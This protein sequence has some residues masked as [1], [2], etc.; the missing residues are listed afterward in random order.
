MSFSENQGLEVPTFGTKGRNQG[1]NPSESVPAAVKDIKRKGLSENSIWLT[2]KQGGSLLGIT[3]RAVK[4]N[5]KAGKYVTTMVDGN[6]GRQYR[7]LLSSLPEKAVM[8]W[9]ME[10]VDLVGGVDKMDVLAGVDEGE[11]AIDLSDVHALEMETPKYNKK[12]FEKYFPFLLSIG[13]F[14]TGELP[15]YSELLKLLDVWNCDRPK[16]LR[17]NYKSLPPLAKKIRLDGNAQSLFGGYGKNRGRSQ[18]FDRIDIDARREI[19]GTFCKNYM[20]PS[21]PALQTCWEV[22]ADVGERLGVPREQLPIPSTFE[23]RLVNELTEQHG[24]SG[25]AII[26]RARY[27]D[28]AYKR[29]YGNFVDRDWSEIEAGSRW[30]FDHAQL[31]LMVKSP[32]GDNVIRFWMTAVLDV[33]SWKLLYYV[34]KT[35][36]PN[37]QD[38]IDAYLGAVKAPNGITEGRQSG[39]PYGVYLDNGK[40]FR[41][42][43]F[44]GKNKKVRIEFGSADKDKIRSVLGKTQCQE[45]TFA[46]PF[47][48]Q[49]KPIERWFRM[50]HDGFERVIGDGYTGTNAAARTDELKEKIKQLDVL[51]Y[52]EFVWALDAF[53]HYQ[54]N[55]PS[56]KR[57]KRQGLSANEVWARTYE[58]RP[59]LPDDI[60]AMMQGRP[61][62]E[63]QITPNGYKDTEVEKKTGKPAVYW[64]HWMSAWI[65]NGKKVYPVRNIEEPERAYFFDAETEEF[66]G[67]GHINFFEV[68]AFDRTD[69]ERFERAWGTIKQIEKA[70]S[71]AIKEVQGGP[72]LTGRQVYRLRVDDLK[73]QRQ[74]EH[75]HIKENTL[76][77][78]KKKTGTDGH[79]LSQTERDAMNDRLNKAALRQIGDEDEW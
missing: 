53:I 74:L 44:S 75:G 2:V 45:V 65:G 77:E 38:I 46:I 10:K 41:S 71:R 24:H 34:L 17:I 33:R 43:A 1:G 64:G 72:G 66:L 16:E 22:A 63:K 20:S 23:R 31:D 13:F 18:A 59:E 61:G 25:E 76:P 5:C 69:D 79:V 3:D 36:T 4:K 11:M 21:A 51:D 7:I 27:G 68:R 54:N 19:Y 8:K 37:S 49:A 70:G 62:K 52:D 73:Q 48:P 56:D 57:S 50:M 58:Q 35:G 15:V 9:R 28:A 30:V 60:I 67:S 55:K 40:D 42:K 47:N 29:K 12:K 39:V 14:K 26:Y 78:A 32:S 6:G